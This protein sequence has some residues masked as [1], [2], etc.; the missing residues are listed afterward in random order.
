VTLGLAA[1]VVGA[2]GRAED[3]AAPPTL[4]PGVTERAESR[5][6][7]FEVRVSRKGA[8]VGG[9]GA[10]DFDIELGGK[11][12]K[13]FTLDDMCGAGRASDAGAP[14]A[15]P[16]S[17]ILY[18]DDPELTMEGRLRAV[19]IARLVSSALL[20]R[21]HDV[22]IMTNGSSVREETKW[23][24]DAAVVSASL[25]RIAS[26]PGNRDHLRAAA[27]EQH[28]AALFE[29]LEASI[30]EGEMNRQMA[31]R[32]AVS[33]NANRRGEFQSTDPNAAETDPGVVAGQQM[34]DSSLS[35]LFGEFHVL[36]QDELQRIERDVERLR[37][38]VRVL[39]LRESPKGVVYFADTLR[40][41][42][43]G[44]AVR[45]VG[46]APHMQKFLRDPRWRTVV[47]RS[48]AN[49]EL[50]A[51]VR[52]AST[53]GVRFYAV[54]GRGLAAESDWVR[55]SQDTLASLALETGGLSFLN[56]LAAERIAD[57]VS[58]DQSCWYLVSFNPSGWDEDR[59]LALGVWLKKPGLRVQTRSALVIPSA[60]TLAETRLIAAHFG[61][62]SVEDR[63]L[64]LSIYPVG[65]TAKRLQVLAQVRLP[66]GDA[67]EAR[68]TTWDIGFD[69]ASHGKIV[70]HDSKRVTWRGS[71]PP[72]IYQ[73]TLS[74][75]A[76][77]YEIVAV[78][79]EA[80][81][82]TVRAGRLTGTWPP[83]P[84]DR[85]TLSV[86]ALAQPQSGGIVLDGEAR[87]SGIVVRGPGNPVDPGAPLAIVTA[88][89]IDGRKDE[90]FHVDRRIV[91][92]TEVS[93][94]PMALGPDNNRCVQIRD[95]VAAGSLG[96]G[97]LTYVVRVRSG[98]VEVASQELAFEVPWAPASSRE[99]SVPPAR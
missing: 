44:I 6:V 42:P 34:V 33:Q 78:A 15:R 30:R 72:P 96:A 54:E 80:V 76:G 95:L 68:D 99:V 64:T 35:R 94:P 77:P 82:D 90:I 88:A 29:R 36:V 55:T 22:L 53:Y 13:A 38:A 28:A 16:G 75:P 57:G 21:G 91:G 9:L 49:E 48:D 31:I 81:A 46:S 3:T 60:A 98:D 40:R 1:I 43:G 39:A 17:F 27:N 84:S 73:T 58:A 56:G 85:V 25:D 2:L 59:P 66:E 62:P 69:V 32:S 71:G 8:P 14:A 65:G 86:P 37:G 19:E 87:D 79:H 10:A 63:P 4:N 83:T 24:H 47:S 61:D 67:P 52:D 26:D 7:Q 74:L 50:T 5:L 93:F 12:L 23:T 97:E 41:D 92:E 20:A 45:A 51:L 18:F 11:P 89:C 70:E